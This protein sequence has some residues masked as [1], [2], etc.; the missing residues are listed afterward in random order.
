MPRYLLETSPGAD[1]HGHC[2]A[3]EWRVRSA[4]AELRRRGVRVRFDRTIRVRHDRHCLFVV[5]AASAREAALAAE[6]A[7]LELVRVVEAVLA[8]ERPGF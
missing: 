2:T 7:E 8:A 5:E 4:A 3:R 6:L 1:G